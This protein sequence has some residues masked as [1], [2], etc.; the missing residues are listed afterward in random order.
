MAER[1]STKPNMF[2]NTELYRAK[3][4]DVPAQDLGRLY[5]LACSELALQQD[6][7][8]YIIKSYILLISV[9]VPLIISLGDKVK[10][11]HSGAILLAVGLT[12]YVFSLIIIRY[13]TYKESYWITCIVLSQLINLEPGSLTKQNIQ[14]MYYKCLKKKWMKCVKE[15]NG[16]K[17]VNYRHLV[18]S[19][20][21]SAETL[22][23]IVMAF[24][25]SVIS[26]LGLDFLMAGCRLGIILS[27]AAS[28][29]LFALLLVRYY[30]NLKDVFRVL[31]DGR[32]DSFNI[33]F[34]K[35]WF[36][37]FYKD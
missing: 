12:G 26:G 30:T 27:F 25:S 10:S 37:H 33:P 23:F 32:N 17:K 7:R 1:M 35:A 24:F 28:L 21:F 19:T 15:K 9:I 20:F 2:R 14:A 36:L 13:R 6:K 29:M 31:V 3:Y 18:R 22:L 34:S 8:D 4:K 11:V 16:K 5:E